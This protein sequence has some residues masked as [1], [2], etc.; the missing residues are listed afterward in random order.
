[1]H[2][3]TKPVLV[4]A[5]E[6]MMLEQF[7]RRASNYIDVSPAKDLFDWMALMRHHGAVT[8]LVDFTHSFYVA[9]FFAVENAVS[10]ST[11]WAVRRGAL[12]ENAYK[13]LSGLDDYSAKFDD[14]SPLVAL[15]LNEWMSK[16][17]HDQVTSASPKRLV[18]PIEP[19]WCHPRMDAQQGLFLV[20]TDLSATFVQNLAGSLSCPEEMLLEPNREFTYTPRVGDELE[21]LE[22]IA[23]Y[24]LLR[25]E[26]TGDVALAALRDLWKMNIHAGTLFPGLDGFARSLNYYAR[27]RALAP[28]DLGRLVWRLFGSP[29]RNK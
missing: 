23:Q 25:I 20:P 9:A 27:G 7:K 22:G 10:A 3:T 17:L 4:R 2:L 6:E 13:A 28:E 24:D 5:A 26:L 16:A 12:W 15:D 19:G 14:N 18:I 8:R 1:L 21:V 11:I 29:P